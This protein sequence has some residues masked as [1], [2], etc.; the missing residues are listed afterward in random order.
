MRFYTGTLLV[1]IV[2]FQ[3][4][5]IQ[6]EAP[7]PIDPSSST[8]QETELRNSQQVSGSD[9][10]TPEAQPSPSYEPEWINVANSIDGNIGMDVDGNSIQLAAPLV[11]YVSR[12]RYVVPKDNASV[13]A[14][15]NVLDCRSGVYQYLSFASFDRQ[16]KTISA[17]Q[18][19]SPPYQTQAGT[20][21]AAAFNLVCSQIPSAYVSNLDEQMA[22][23]AFRNQYEAA[24]GMQDYYLRMR[25]QGIEMLNS[26]YSQRFDSPSN[27][28]YPCDFPWQ[29]DSMGRQ[30]GDRAATER[31]GGRW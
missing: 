19:Q 18:R 6:Q 4:C 9:Y 7:H 16:G 17:G 25:Q 5:S 24:E 15:Q 3:G 13:T 21:Q 10:Q 26:A 1:S 29:Y 14:V 12:E 11:F 28:Y 27:G 20:L 2:V 23:E 8:H 30:C 31:P 22:M